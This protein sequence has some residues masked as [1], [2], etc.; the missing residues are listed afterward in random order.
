M[1]FIA[2]VGVG[3]AGIL[4]VLYQ[5]TRGS[6]DPMIQKQALA[7]A[8]SLL[9]E[10]QLKPFT[11]C[12]PDDPNAAAAAGP[13]AC[14]GGALGP[15]DESRLV[16]GQ[17]GPE[18]AASV[19][20]AEGRYAAPQFDNVSDYHGFAMGPGIQD[21]TNTTIAGLGAYAAT[22]AVAE[23]ALGTVPAADSLRITV[24]VTGPANTT[25]VLQGFRTRYAP[26][27]L[28]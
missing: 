28:P 17:L 13:A 11:W 21:I 19:G 12:D 7:I 20:G 9:E 24:T 5:T 27:T 15:N 25:V 3:V 22:I 6:A 2:I 1:V 23:T 14:T 26:N 16:L 8:E 10:V 4:S 18:T